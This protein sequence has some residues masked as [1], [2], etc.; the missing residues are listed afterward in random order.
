MQIFKK[1]TLQFLPLPPPQNRSL[2]QGEAGSWEGPGHPGQETCLLLFPNVALALPIP[3][4][5]VCDEK[6]KC[7][8]EPELP[9]RWLLLRAWLRGFHSSREGQSQASEG[10]TGAPLTQTGRGQFFELTAR[11]N[12]V[13]RAWTPAR[14]REGTRVRE[15]GAMEGF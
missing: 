14:A 4:V 15:M 2:T 10:T 3:V 8:V 1:I 9:P 6:E 12:K 7:Q 11:H 13:R 5:S